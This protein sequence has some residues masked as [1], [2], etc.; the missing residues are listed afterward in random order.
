M[1]L[2]KKTKER[3]IK[4]SARHD[5]DTGS[6]EVQIS[7]TSKQ[8]E[9]LSEHLKKNRKDVHS[10]R[11]LLKLVSKRRKILS[12]LSKKDPAKHAEMIKIIKA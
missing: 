11:G 1:A 4:G 8:I 9:K 7:L 5:T 3:I 10:R 6:P 2:G 12:H